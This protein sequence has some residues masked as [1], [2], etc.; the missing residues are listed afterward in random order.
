MRLLFIGDIM[1]RPGRR[2]PAQQLDA[3][4]ARSI[5]RLHCDETI[6]APECRVRV[7]N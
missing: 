3:L 6:A 5:R 1:G 7:A 4:R 2:I